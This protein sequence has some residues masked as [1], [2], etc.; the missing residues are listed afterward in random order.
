MHMMQLTKWCGFSFVLHLGIG[1][2]FILWAA[3]EIK[4]PPKAMII[5][6]DSMELPD[7]PRP[8]PVRELAKAAPRP[9][10]APPV[11]VRQ[12]VVPAPRP[13]V[14][15]SVAAPVPVATVP[16]VLR[17]EASP[18]REAPRPQA[19]QPAPVLSRPSAVAPARAVQQAAAEVR[20][21]QEPAQQRYLKENFAYI[22][23]LVT[24]HLAYP[25]LARKM[26][27][28]GKTQV[29]FTIAEDGSVHALRTVE[30]SGYPLLDK[31]ALETVRSV[32][33]FPKP[34]VRAE[35]ILPVHFRM[36]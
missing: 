21:A 28:S 17:A 11:P 34:P 29:G 15:P 9:D 8:V 2:I 1:S 19:E 30:S 26:G 27:W 22:R 12:A 10:A 16:A 13:A 33:P 36:Q 14:A 7:L 5:M 25:S 24:K 32:A 18:P 35:I 23:E 3:H 6:L 31:S 4:H 20:P